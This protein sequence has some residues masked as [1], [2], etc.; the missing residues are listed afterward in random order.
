MGSMDD[1]PP[2]VKPEHVFPT[3]PEG[4]RHV[5]AVMPRMVLVASTALLALVGCVGSA[6]L[7]T[8]TN[9]PYEERP[10]ADQTEAGLAARSHFDAVHAAIANAAID[11]S[12]AER[13]R[14]EALAC[15]HS[16][17]EL[18]NRDLRAASG[19]DFVYYRHKDTLTTSKGVLTL[20]EVQTRCLDLSEAV[21]RVCLRSWK[22]PDPVVKA[23]EL[24]FLEFARRAYPKSDWRA[25]VLTTADWRIVRH[26]ESGVVTGRAREFLVAGRR[27]N[28][29]CAFEYMELYQELV[30][31]K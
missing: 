18:T 31:D 22:L 28:G 29:T 27:E 24:E 16:V 8:M 9:P 30:A 1:L 26:P 14:V 2:G 10:P 25:V 19:L 3:A 11:Q 12:S 6:T 4:A 5:G 17:Q 7:L 13:A 23:S 20:D 21:W 15:S